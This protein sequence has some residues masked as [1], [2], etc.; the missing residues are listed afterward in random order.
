MKMNKEEIISKINQFLI[1][2]IEIDE[3]DIVPQALL[4]DDLGIDS[5]DFVD[6]VVIIEK[7]FGFKIKG[8]DMKEIKTLAQF[9]DFVESKLIV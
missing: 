9:Y 3:N 8:E 2:D 7:T 1:E 6:I 4:Y 5:L